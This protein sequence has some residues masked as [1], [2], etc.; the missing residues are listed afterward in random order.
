MGRNA[1]VNLT[2][3]E[4][5]NIDIGFNVGGM[6]GESNTIRI[7]NNNI[8]DAFVRGISGTTIASGA[9]VLVDSD[10]HLG[11]VTSSERFKENIKPMDKASETLFSLKPITFRYKKEIDPNGTP[12]FGLVAEDVEKISPDLVVRDESGRVNSVR[13]QTR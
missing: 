6:T 11:T 7:G 5:N 13:Y 3:N 1:G 4:S 10:G 2:T 8:T 9:T 12:Q